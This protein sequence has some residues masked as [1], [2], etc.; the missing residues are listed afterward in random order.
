MF[1]ALLTVH[2]LSQNLHAVK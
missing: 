1:Y 2:V